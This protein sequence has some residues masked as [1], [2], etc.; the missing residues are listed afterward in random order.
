MLCFSCGKSNQGLELRTP[1]N[2]SRTNLDHISTSGPAIVRV[3]TMISIRIGDERLRRSR[4]LV[5]E[6]VMHSTLQI[7][8]HM[9]CSLPVSQ[10]RIGVEPGK[11]SGCIGNVWTSGD[12]QI[13]QRAYNRNVGVLAHF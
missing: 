13:H 5:D 8:K 1:G 12:C 7:A 4:G 2:R 6:L 3:S 9:L 11:N 10:S